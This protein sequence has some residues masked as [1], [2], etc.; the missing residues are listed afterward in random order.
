MIAMLKNKMKKSNKQAKTNNNEQTCP[1]PPFNRLKS[2]VPRKKIS[3][4]TY[5]GEEEL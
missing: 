4:C 5:L 1:N 3:S 2:G